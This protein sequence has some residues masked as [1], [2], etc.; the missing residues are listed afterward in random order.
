MIIRA[1]SNME[2]DITGC[3]HGLLECGNMS[4]EADVAARKKDKRRRK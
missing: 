4:L 1:G 3:K 2:V